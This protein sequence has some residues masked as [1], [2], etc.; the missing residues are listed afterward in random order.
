MILERDTE[1]ALLRGLLDDLDTTGGKVVLLRGEAGIGKSALVSEFIAQ[2]DNRAHI[3]LGGCDDL[4]TPQALGPFWDMAREEPSLRQPLGESDRLGVLHACLD[5]LSRSLRPTIMVF[6]DTH[7]ADEATLDAIMYLGRRIARSNGLLL[8]TYRDG[9]VDFDHPLRA[10]VG[11]LPPQTV[12][13]IQLQGLSLA[14][15]TSILGDSYL[16]PGDVAAATGGNPLLV[17]EMASNQEDTIPASIQDSVMTRLAKLPSDTQELVKTLSVI[18]ESV[19]LSELRRLTGAAENLVANAE[20][21]GLLKTRGSF[22]VFG[23][24]LIRRAIESSLTSRDAIAVN[25]QVLAALPPGSDPARLVH[26]ARQAEDTDRLLEVA[27][28]AA[29]AAASVGSHREAAAHFRL[30]RNAVD[31]LN[32]EKGPFLDDWAEVEFVL[33]NTSE[34]IE[35]TETAIA[36]YRKIGDSDGE[37]GALI[38]AAHYCEIVGERQRCEQYAAQA[39]A[40]L[41]PQPAPWNLARALEINAFVQVQASNATSA[42]LFIDRTAAAASANDD[43]V[44]IRIL[45]HR[46]VV[47]DL[48]DYPAGRE[49]LEKARRKAEDTGELYEESR[50][51][52][53]HAWAAVANRDLAIATDFAQRAIAAA[54]KYQLVTLEAYSKALLATA[55]LL[56]G[57]FDRAEN[58]ARSLDP[59]IEGRRGAMYKAVA[60]PVVGL[61]EARTGRDVLEALP[62]VWNAFRGVEEF[63]R[64]GPIAETIAEVAWISGN[65]DSAPIPDLHKVMEMGLKRGFEWMSGSIAFRLWLL[66]A[67]HEIPEGIAE[68]YRL[69]IEDDSEGAAEIWER[70][71]LP[72][73]RALALMHSDEEAQLEALKALDELGATAVAAKLRKS[74]RDLGITVPRGKDLKTRDHPAGLTARQAEVL[75]LLAQGLSNPKIADRLFISPR[76]VENHVTAVLTKLNAIDRGEAVD[77]ARDRGLLSE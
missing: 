38:R 15:V 13:R 33:D 65:T 29:R 47:A 26:H 64:V 42:G 22:V 70:M 51:L 5:L 17:T 46:G 32:S 7:W 48:I 73:E 37:S 66:G 72:Y 45:N 55:Q 43:W 23:H 67:L 58:L 9:V 24:E 35:L 52:M 12:N 36:H 11:E 57:E 28:V 44:Q 14:A 19:S 41:D 77:I 10:V 56:G 59:V 68:P 3:L 25:R 69:V 21:H 4:L 6:E 8:L 60:I 27:P 18:P 74:M 20:K 76:T 16:D 63:Q 49:D 2:S 53:N 54:S 75:D 62:A 30:L 61:V 34:A 71:G 1:L 31:R 50:A 39:L 40:A